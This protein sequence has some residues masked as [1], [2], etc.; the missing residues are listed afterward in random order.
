[1]SNLLKETLLDIDWNEICKDATSNGEAYDKLG[2]D[3]ELLNRWFSEL[4]NIHKDN[5]AL[6]FIYEAHASANDFCAALSLGLYKLTATSIRTILESLLNF[7]YYKDHHRELKTLVT[8]DSFYL[9]KKE[10]IEYHKLHTPDFNERASE[11]NTVD[12]LNKLYKEISR[13]IHGQIPGQWYTNPELKNKKHEQDTFELAVSYFNELVKIITQFHIS[14][15]A[16][17][18]WSSMNFR[19]RNLFLKGLDGDKKLKLK[20][21]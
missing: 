6:P 17:S 7:S 10:I 18:E 19:S 21:S 9:G 1:M 14:S 20:R 13:I 8:N 15:L 16:D 5:D 4:I 11:L 12:N 2:K 3:L